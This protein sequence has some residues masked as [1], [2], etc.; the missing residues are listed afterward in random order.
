VLVEVEDARGLL[1]LLSI[2]PLSTFAS[3]SAK[4]MFSRTVMCGYSA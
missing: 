1:D 2:S 4:P 3:L